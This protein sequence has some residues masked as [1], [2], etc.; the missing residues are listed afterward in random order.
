MYISLIEKPTFEENENHI[1]CITETS[2][3]T[4][5]ANTQL[6]KH[7]HRKKNTE[8]SCINKLCTNH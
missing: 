4:T 2:F 1:I 7:F 3:R 8:K 6:V 5:N